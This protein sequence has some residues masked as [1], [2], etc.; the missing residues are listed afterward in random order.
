LKKN[1]IREASPQKNGS[2]R[3]MSSLQEIRRM[4]MKIN[5]QTEF[6]SNDNEE[7]KNIFED[8]RI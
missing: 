3:F 2:N 6:S 8:L 5:N 1:D 7:D 4:M